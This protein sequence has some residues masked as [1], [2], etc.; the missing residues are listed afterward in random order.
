MTRCGIGPKF[1]IATVLFGM[2]TGW[3]T[4]LFPNWFIISCVPYWILV[5]LGIVFL[6]LG[7]VA[8]VYSLSVFNRGYRNEQLVIDGPYL[9]VRHP[10]YAAWILLI[11]PGTVLFFRSWIMLLVPLAA[12]ISF[13]ICIHKED[14]YLK[15]KFGQPY[16]DY[17]S[18]VN[19]LFPNWNF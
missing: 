8:Y 15:D 16:S 11:C 14:D 4:Y 18:K 17:R 7:V 19:E 13:K 12:Y 9:I 2:L 3:L 6:V 10:I 5:V 1:S